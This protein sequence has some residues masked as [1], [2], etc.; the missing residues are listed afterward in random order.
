MN[1][2]ERTSKYKPPAVVETV[3]KP[4]E[5]TVVGTLTVLFAET[6]AIGHKREGV[7]ALEHI[8]GLQRLVADLTAQCLVTIQQR[9][10][11]AAATQHNVERAFLAKFNIEGK[12]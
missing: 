7:I 5:P 3:E 6:G 1:N 10:V 8:I 12:H 11:Q 2:P 9:E 4:V